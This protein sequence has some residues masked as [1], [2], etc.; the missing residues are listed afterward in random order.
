MLGLRYFTMLCND[1]EYKNM[2]QGE[3]L[4]QLYGVQNWIKIYYKQSRWAYS[5]STTSILNCYT[6][7]V[8]PLIVDD[9]LKKS[10]VPF[11]TVLNYDHSGNLQL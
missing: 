1:A 4:G 3:S 8:A 6:L 9:N 7:S 11:V 10:A 5:S 2:D